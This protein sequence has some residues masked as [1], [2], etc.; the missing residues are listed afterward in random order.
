MLYYSAIFATWLA[1]MT[2]HNSCYEHCGIILKTWKIRQ[3]KRG[4]KNNF[5]KW[6]TVK[7]MYFI[8]TF[9]NVLKSIKCTKIHYIKRGPKT[10]ETSFRVDSR[11]EGFSRWTNFFW[12]FDASD[13]EGH[14]WQP[15]PF[16]CQ[17]RPKNKQ[18]ESKHDTLDSS[19]TINR[20]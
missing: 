12:G 19:W 5:S 20:Y 2:L 10:S 6:C 11:P 3:I 8:K 7:I 4:Y 17:N 9:S 18:L 15:C 16:S 1:I 14:S 13:L